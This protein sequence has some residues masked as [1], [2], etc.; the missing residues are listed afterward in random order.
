MHRLLIALLLFTVALFSSYAQPTQILPRLDQVNIL[1]E[2]MALQIEITSGIDDMYNFQFSRAESQFRWLKKYYSSHP[3]PYFLLALNRWW[4]M[5][6]NLANE[7]YD[8]AFNNYL[9]STIY[10]AN[11]LFKEDK[12]NIEATFFLSAAYGFRGCLRGERKLWMKAAI[13]GK[14]S[15]QYLNYSKEKEN[16]SIEFLFGHALYNY[17]S[18][19]I[20]EH[21]RSL[22]MLLWFFNKGNKKLGIKQLETVVSEA[23]YTRVEGQIYL[24]RM[25]DGE[26]RRPEALKIARELHKK[27]PNN[28]YFHRYYARMLYLMSKGKELE[29]ASTAILD[30]LDKKVKGYEETSGRYASFFLGSRYRGSGKKEAAIYHLRK[31]VEYAEKSEA[32]GSGYYLLSLYYLGQYAEKD[33]D[34]QQ[35]KYHYDKLLTHGSKKQGYYKSGKNSLKNIGKN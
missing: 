14:K 17:Y 29:K 7:Q 4:Q 32:F 26:G 30:R 18:V 2:N 19:W 1:L 34:L 24:M 6:P 33:Q 11:K 9:D 20:R 23:F 35:A 28:P 8:Q 27:Y 22:R 31:S 10:F 5:M 3:L 25:Y 16:L 13:S 15:L 12:E 21:Y